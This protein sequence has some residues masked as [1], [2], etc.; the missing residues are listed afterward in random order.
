MTRQVLT[1]LIVGPMVLLTSVGL[2]VVLSGA[3]GYRS[4]RQAP[5]PRSKETKMAIFRIDLQEG[6]R[7]DVVV[8]RVDGKEVFNK[9]GVETNLAIAL[10]D[11]VEL[12]IP[13][14]TVKVEVAVPSRN[15]SESVTVV[16]KDPT[17]LA[18]SIAARGKIMHKTSRE[19]FPY[20]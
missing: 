9:T 10:A 7:N 2:T 1:R 13:E 6:F 11:S 16:V 8:I 19:P 3:G 18:F 14:G 15:L 4:E 12:N 17:Y 20:M 5:L